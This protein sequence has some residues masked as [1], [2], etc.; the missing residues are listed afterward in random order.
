[1]KDCKTGIEKILIS[2]FYPFSSPIFCF[3]LFQSKNWFDSQNLLSSVYYI[4]KFFHPVK[5]EGFK[6]LKS[7]EK[8]KMKK[9]SLGI[10][11]MKI[12]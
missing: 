6:I 3:Y 5:E 2:F 11:S 1:L 9:H 8:T 12:F 7:I 10:I 4:F